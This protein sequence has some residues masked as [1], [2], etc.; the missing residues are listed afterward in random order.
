MKFKDQTIARFLS[1][2]SSGTPTPGGGSTAALAGAFAAGLI[3]MVCN[4]TIGKRTYQ[5]V[6]PEMKRI[7]TEAQACRDELLELSDRDTEAFE[8]VMRAYKL[9]K[10]TTGQAQKRK[11]DLEKALM[12]ATRVP[13]RVAEVC[14]RLLE[15]SEV[16]A[17]E[18]NKN[19]VSDAG[20]AACLAEAAL[21]GALLNV[22]INLRLLADK[23]FK[24]EYSKKSALL[25]H[26]AKAR[27]DS[28]MAKVQER[29]Q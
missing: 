3:C 11:L 10:E 17:K 15:F 8:N 12:E 6:E 9:P 2:L 27:R 18:G 7:L 26:E 19:A 1:E 23:S 29:L 5:R 28:V 21:Q 4:L 25:L 20:V 16:L 14:A 13:Y 24:E 22:T